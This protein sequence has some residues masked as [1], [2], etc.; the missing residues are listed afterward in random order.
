MVDS[1][2]YTIFAG[3]NGAGKSTLY[4][5]LGENRF[6]V[7]LNLDDIVKEMGADWKSAKAYVDAGRVLLAKQDYCLDKGISFNRETTVPGSSIIQSIKMAKARGFKIQLLYV[8]VES[9]EIAR[10][11]VLKRVA[12]GGHGVNDKTLKA[13]YEIIEKQI[14]KILPYCDYVQM[15]DN[16]LDKI[17]LVAYSDNGF[18]LQIDNSCKWIGKVFDEL[19]SKSASFERELT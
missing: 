16:S 18:L 3:V 4:Y 17:K 9:L 6:G 19:D 8:G 11:R 5:T 2:V 7:R 14:S 1:R 15:F 12:H 10:E 13:R